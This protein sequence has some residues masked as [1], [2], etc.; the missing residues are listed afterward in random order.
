MPVG[1]AP[2]VVCLLLSYACWLWACC[3]VP[4]VVVCL[5]GCVGVVRLLL[6]CACCCR[7]PC[8][9]CWLVAVVCLVGCVCVVRLLLSCACCCRAPCWLC[10]C[11]VGCVLLVVSCWLCPVG[12]VGVLF[13]SCLRPVGCVLLVGCCR[14]PVAFVRLLFGCLYVFFGVP[15]FLV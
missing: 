6:L 2:V 11:P 15:V 4:V 8:W 5:D 3:R 14:A 7:A 1:C 9:L 10:W 13:A 12:C